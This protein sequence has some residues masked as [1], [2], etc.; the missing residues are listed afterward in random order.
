MLS[1]E[2]E[3]TAGPEDVWDL[4]AKPS[5]WHRWAPHVRGGVGLG[6]PEVEAGRR[7]FVRLLG[8][9]PVPTRITG[10]EPGRRWTWRVGLIDF[11]HDVEPSASGA[12]VRIT[13]DA[14]APLEQALA[15][16][17]GPAISLLL[18]SLRRTAERRES[19]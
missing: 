16:T 15:V 19:A 2:I 3:S 7:G 12:R 4:I 10:K 8:L 14:P 5:E 6:E 18:R 1:Y 17:Y 9:I 13:I 11:S